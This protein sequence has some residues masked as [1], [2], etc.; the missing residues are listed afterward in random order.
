MNDQN[1]SDTLDNAVRRLLQWRGIRIT[2][3]RGRGD[4][5]FMGLPDA[6]YESPMWA[7]AN[8]HVST[9]YLKSERRGTICLSCQAQI[10]LVPQITQ[11]EIAEVMSNK[12]EIV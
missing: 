10:W 8:G 1:N 7:C 4:R 6:W 12:K 11:A 2:E 3:A 5:F 9:K